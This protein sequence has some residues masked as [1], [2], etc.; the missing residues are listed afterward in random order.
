M[1]RTAVNV[2]GDACGAV[3]VARTE[4][5]HR[6]RMTIGA[7]TLL[8]S[9]GV[10][11]QLRFSARGLHGLRLEQ[12]GAWACDPTAKVPKDVRDCVERLPDPVARQGIKIPLIYDETFSEFT[13]T[14][15]R[16]LRDQVGPG[17]IVRYGELAKWRANLG[18]RVR[19]ARSWVRTP[20]HF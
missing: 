5:E 9:E 18:Q 12:E 6:A 17:R 3:T 10:I 14:V 8:V 19:L 16:T 15:W 7:W 2:T 4:G 1:C 11:A 13:H 20:F